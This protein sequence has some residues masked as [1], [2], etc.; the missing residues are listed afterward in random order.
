MGLP[1]GKMILFLFKELKEELP[2]SSHR[3]EVALFIAGKKKK[4]YIGQLKVQWLLSL[5]FPAHPSL[6]TTAF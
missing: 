6:S 3:A 4:N 5:S 1:D 2:S